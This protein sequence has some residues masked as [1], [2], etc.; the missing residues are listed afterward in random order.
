M[1]SWK[2]FWFLPTA[3][4]AA[5]ALALWSSDPAVSDILGGLAVLG[6]A[7]FLVLTMAGHVRF[8]GVPV[9]EMDSDA[10]VTLTR[11]FR[12]GRFGR[13]EILSRLEA[14]DLRLGQPTHL[15]PEAQ[16]ALVTAPEPE[17]LDY[18]E[19]RILRVERAS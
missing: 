12:G 17:F 5:I 18:V 9:P 3:A 14:L 19:A 10:L 15:S 11:S 2:R 13:E 8:E 7:V 6:A 4:L 1:N 16:E